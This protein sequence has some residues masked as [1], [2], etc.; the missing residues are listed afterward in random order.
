M[1]LFIDIVN[2]TFI[3]ITIGVIGYY[4][5]IV[6]SFIAGFISEII[7]IFNGR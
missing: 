4:T 3:I 2:G 6:G 5:I 1:R 7:N